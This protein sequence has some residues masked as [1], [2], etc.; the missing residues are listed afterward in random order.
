MSQIKIKKLAS[1]RK[2]F[3]S[4]SG[5]NKNMYVAIVNIQDLPKEFEDWLTIN[6]REATPNTGV[7]KLIRDS[8]IDRPDEFIFR[9]RGLTVIAEKVSF[10]NHANIATLDMSNEKIH[11]LLDGGHTYRVIQSELENLTDDK[12]DL[13][14]AY[15]RI[16]LLEGFEDLDEVVDIV[17]ARNKSAQ[18]KEQSLAELRGLFDTIKE[19][20]NGQSYSNRIAYKEIELLDDGSKKDID[21]KDI[22][23]YLMCFDT[24]SFTDK[25]HPI[26]AY[27]SKGSVL[28]MYEKNPD[29]MKKYVALL[30]K[31]LQLV[32]T[33]KLL[34]PI[35]YVKQG[36][37]WG[38][39][40]GVNK[41]DSE[42]PFISSFSE[43]QTPNGFIY[44]ILAAFRSLVK[45]EKNKVEWKAEP[46]GFL[47]EIKSLLAETIG[48]QAISVH[49]PNKLGKDSATWRLCYALVALEV[50]KRGY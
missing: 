41:E 17:Y 5:K 23:S 45:V 44:P 19:I 24:E 35:E 13:K 32:D 36:G 49:N 25:N 20:L 21:I 1:F 6:P 15:V 46:L 30:P 48:E 10:D 16:E 37:K 4:P 27:S 33:I 47:T 34:I 50:A 11:G 38:K 26:A 40:L 39:L 3:S 9:N 2:V 29:H 22:V 43:Y 31:I 42:L 7:G 12:S 18:V 8:L 14:Q 28:K